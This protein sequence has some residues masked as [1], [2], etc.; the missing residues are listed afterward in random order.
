HSP[1][2]PR[3]RRVSCPRE[4]QHDRLAPLIR[5]DGP[6]GRAARDDPDA[7]ARRARPEFRRL[8]CPNCEKPALSRAVAHAAHAALA[9]GAACALTES[10][11]EREPATGRAGDDAVEMDHPGVGAE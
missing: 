7:H 5:V 10:G 2:L 4:P 6:A 1:R 11:P 3:T 9:D 8:E